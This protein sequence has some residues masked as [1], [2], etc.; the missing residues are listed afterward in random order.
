MRGHRAGAGGGLVG[1]VDRREVEEFLDHP[2][3]EAG[4]VIFVEPIVERGWEQEALGLA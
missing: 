2:G 1:R 4:L 3:D